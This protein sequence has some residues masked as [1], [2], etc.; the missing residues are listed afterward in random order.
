MTL[1]I[2]RS[3]KRLDI[4]TKVAGQRKF[5]QD[6]DRPGQLYTKAVWAA[7][8]H[9]RVLRIDTARA[10][11]VPGVVDV[12][13]AGDVPVNEYGIMTYDQQVLIPVGGKTRW[14]G[15]RIAVVVAETSAAAEQACGLVAVDYEV[16]DPITDPR[17]AMSEKTLVHP[18]KDSNVIKHLWIRRG[19]VDEA[20]ARA[21]V[22]VEG[23][24]ETPWVEHAYLQPEA[25]LGYVDEDGRL[26]LIVATQWPQDD[27]RQLAHLLDEPDTEV[28]LYP[29][30]ECFQ[31]FVVGGV[32]GRSLYFHG[33]TVSATRP[34]R[35]PD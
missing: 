11:A 1:A 19:S 3:A 2:G 4:T 31:V 34:V 24:Y 29:S 27:I 26:A 16:L 9:A 21:D 15:D 7:H 20:F 5:P 33:G 22:V 25:C 28:H 14:M 30:A 35:L 12:L 8:P 10:K 23:T 6:F 13:T 17:R 18:E 32:A